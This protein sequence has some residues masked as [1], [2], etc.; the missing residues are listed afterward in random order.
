MTEGN[1][2]KKNNFEAVIL[3]VAGHKARLYD[4]LDENGKQVGKIRDAVNA[5]ADHVYASEVIQLLNGKPN[6]VFNYEIHAYFGP[7][8]ENCSGEPFI[9]PGG[10][11]TTNQQGK[12][13]LRV[14]VGE[15]G[16]L[17]SKNPIPIPPE[18]TNAVIGFRY[19]VKAQDGSANYRTECQKVWEPAPGSTGRP[20]SEWTPL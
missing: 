8:A 9:Q 1:F 11:I 12:G 18:V 3:G 5:K 2:N 19:W 10:T 6:T 15:P 20:P 17:N 14:V 13:F 16:N 4:L 7:A